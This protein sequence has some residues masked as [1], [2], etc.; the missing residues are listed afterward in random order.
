M[1]RCGWC[2]RS[3]RMREVARCG[4]CAVCCL[5]TQRIS[6]LEKQISVTSSVEMDS[7]SERNCVKIMTTSSRQP[8]STQS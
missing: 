3:G 6:S 5:E 8:R 1:L 7:H 2:N 4:A